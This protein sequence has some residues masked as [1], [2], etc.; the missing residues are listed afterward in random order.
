MKK[1]TR[2]IHKWLGLLSCLFILM[3]AVTA[4]ALNHREQL[5]GL[6]QHGSSVFSP[7]GIKVMATD[8]FN[9]RQIIASDFKKLFKSANSGKTWQELK[10]FVPADNVN[11]IAF[12]PYEHDKVFISLKRAGIYFSEDGGEVWDELSL[13]FNPAEGENIENVSLSRNEVHVKTR[14]A[15]YNYNSLTEKWDTVAFKGIDRQAAVRLD[16]LIYNIHSGRI[17]GEFGI[18]IYDTLSA[19]LILLAISGIY[20][21]LRPRIRIKPGSRI[22]VS[23]EIKETSDIYGK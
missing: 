11:N 6:F 9:G 16:E 3:V 17:F 2:L 13:P 14:F 23:N 4:V 15:L 7:A 10:L 21:S 19:G 12:D 18:V 20:L 22:T 1:T 5:S 8:P